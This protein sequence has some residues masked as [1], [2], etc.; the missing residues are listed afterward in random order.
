MFVIVANFRLAM[1]IAKKARQW[2]QKHREAT[3]VWTASYLGKIFAIPAVVA[4]ARQ[5]A[6]IGG[7]PFTLF[8]K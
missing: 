8:R 1:I 2:Q 3:N 4:A 5:Y 6:E 7:D